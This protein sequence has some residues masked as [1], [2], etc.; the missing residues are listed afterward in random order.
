MELSFLSS[1]VSM[2]VAL[3]TVAVAVY[4][5]PLNSKSKLKEEYRFAKEFLVDIVENKKLHHLAVERGYYAIAGTSSIKVSD[6]IYLVS[7]VAPDK[8]I[9]DYILARVYVEFDEVVQKIVFK[10]RYKNSG[11]RLFVKVSYSVLYVVFGSL[12]VAPYLFVGQLTFL[13][14]LAVVK[15]VFLLFFGF[16]ALRFLWA[17]IKMIRG[18]ALLGRQQKHLPSIFYD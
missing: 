17:F 12:A 5:L 2:V 7:L 3:V 10:S 6:L 9:K 14:D 18:E 8:C 16:F 15:L 4:Q 1:I 13:P 11:Y